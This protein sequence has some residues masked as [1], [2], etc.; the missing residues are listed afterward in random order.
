[1]ETAERSECLRIIKSTPAN[2]KALLKGLPKAVLLWTPAPGKWSILEIVC[3]IRDMEEHAYLDRFR[4]VLAE[5]EPTLPDIDGDV[6]SLQNDY[7]SQKLSAVLSEWRRLRRESLKVLSTV[8]GE[9][10]QR[11]GIHEA[12]GPLSL[13]DLLHRLA[14]GNDRA[15]L[16]QIEAIKKRHAL[17]ER[18]ASTP[19]RVAKALKA[20]PAEALRRPPAPGKWSAVEIACHLRDVDRLYAERMSKAAFSDR[21]QWWMMD[22]DRVAAKLRYREADPTAVLREYRRRREDLVSLLRALPHA[23]WQR[24]G[25]HPK[26]G[27]LSIEQ[28]AEVIAGHDDHHLKQIETLAAG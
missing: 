11:V 3:H 19:A 18:L 25:V 28:H 9:Q 13:D 15:H 8:K 24:T 14:Y 5:N 20:M 21:P 27:E 4:R 12:A 10:W 2:L 16:E 1:M 17:L 6:Y 22:N 26:R 23:A 7:R